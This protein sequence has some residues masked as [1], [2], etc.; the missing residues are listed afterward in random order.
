[1]VRRD[2]QR[3]QEHDRRQGRLFPEEPEAD[4]RPPPPITAFWQPVG[5]VSL[6][7]ASEWSGVR[8]FQ[9]REWLHAGRLRVH[10]VAA[11]VY[12]EY[13]DVLAAMSNENPETGESS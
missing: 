9:L 12:V 2:P 1:M 11:S 8:P 7:L 4:E 13:A 3:R 10:H 6:A 5:L